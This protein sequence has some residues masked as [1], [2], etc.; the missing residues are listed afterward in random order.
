MST[1]A[2]SQYEIERKKPM[3]SFNHS[4][5]QANLITELNLRYRKQLTVASE[6]SLDL[7]DWESV[8]DLSIY[9]K[10]QLDLKNDVIAM[11]EPPLCVVEII[12][13]TQSLNDLVAKAREYFAHE[14]KSCWIVIPT[15]EN[16]YVFS[17]PNDYQMFRSG[18]EL[19]DPVLDIAFPLTAVFE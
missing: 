17:S 16:I 14:V 7:S 3:P 12:S 6:L 18:D 9:P 8:P 11:T 13:P 4:I 19:R 10:K 1:V 15:L 5:I 2:L